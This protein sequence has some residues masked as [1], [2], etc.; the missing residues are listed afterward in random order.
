[1]KNDY[2]REVFQNFEK[3]DELK[4]K[5]N[6]FSGGFGKLIAIIVVVLYLTTG[7]F[8]VGPDEE[9][10]I[11]R[12]GKYLKTFGPGIHW[13]FPRPIARVIKVKTTKVYRIEVGFRTVEVG[14]P[15]RYKNVKEE[16]LML[17][18]DENILDIDFIVQY[19]IEDVLKY[20]FNLKDPYMMLK[21][22]SEAT[23]R[24]VVGKSNIEETLTVGKDRIQFE[25][26][27]KLQEVLDKYE[28]GIQ[29]IGVQLQD[30]QP[31]EQ[32]IG[33]FKDVASAREDR[34]RYINEANGYLN[35]LIPKARGGAQ[36]LLNEAYAYKEK[37]V[38]EAEGDVA[39]FLK[40]YENY[41]LGKDVT[42]TRLYLETLENVLPDTDK[43]II[44]KDLE[45]GILNILDEKGAVSK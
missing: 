40:L 24:Q 34:V 7:T 45:S 37:R 41:N 23:L 28:S 25:T 4:K 39:K 19:K 15:A 29:I 30:V 31:P 18:G 1:M 14:P 33:A 27:D 22:A 32:V 10:V 26:K 3:I 35:D 13:Y 36:Q 44:D 2:E 12:F 16:S 38:K 8:S 21:D 43:V 9:A 42:R 5:L 20:T 17:T 6:N 11:L